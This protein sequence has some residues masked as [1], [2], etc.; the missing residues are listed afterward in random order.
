MC[1]TGAVVFVA[2]FVFALAAMAPSAVLARQSQIID[3]FNRPDTAALSTSSSGHLW[4]VYAGSIHVAEGQAAM[5]PG[6]GLAAIDAGTS[7]VNL[8]L[9]V[10]VAVPEFGV[11]LRLAD[12]SNYWRFGAFAG[13]PYSLQEVQNNALGTPAV[14]QLSTIYPSDGDVLACAVRAG[15]WAADGFNRPDGP[16]TVAD[17][18]KP[19]TA[20]WG[21]FYVNDDTIVSGPGFTLATLVSDSG[22]GDLSAKIVAPSDEFWVVFRLS[23]AAN[24]WRFGRWHGEGYQLQRIRVQ[25]ATIYPVLSKSCLP[26]AMVYVACT[27]SSR[28]SAL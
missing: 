27:G 14:D 12:G 9:R 7:S 22:A 26:P 15:P 20:H 11:V 1:L 18:G 17:S 10:A 24:Y 6:F 16:L 3:D 4:T 19:W 5:G 8:E 2:A 28:S 25:G 13:Q 21:A 23:D